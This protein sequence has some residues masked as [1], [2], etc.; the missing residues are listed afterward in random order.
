MRRMIVGQTLMGGGCAYADVAS[1][2]RRL[3][4]TGGRCWKTYPLSKKGDLVSQ[5]RE[6]EITSSVLQLRVGLQEG[7]S[8]SSSSYDHSVATGSAAAHTVILLLYTAQRSWISH[9]IYL[10]PVFGALLQW[11]LNGFVRSSTPVLSEALY[12]VKLFA[13]VTLFQLHF[14][15]LYAQKQIGYGQVIRDTN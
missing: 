5:Q 9:A 14:Y 4:T 1:P 13:R 3:R 6:Q 8:S 12:L 10:L 15:A 11:Y 2:F 7:S